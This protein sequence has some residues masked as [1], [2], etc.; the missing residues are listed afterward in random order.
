M[1]R[2]IL[3]ERNYRG[4]FAYKTELNIEPFLWNLIPGTTAS[5]IPASLRATIIARICRTAGCTTVSGHFDV[6]TRTYQ[7]DGDRAPTP[8]T[9]YFSHRRGGVGCTSALVGL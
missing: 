1:Y 3:Y 6:C 7:M 8:I 4:T 5:A 2:K 9:A